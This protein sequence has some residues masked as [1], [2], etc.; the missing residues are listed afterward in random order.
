MERRSFLGGITVA[1][2]SR[3][4]GTAD[5]DVSRVYDVRQFGASG[6]G[7]TDDTIAIRRALTELNKAGGVLALPPGDYVVSA[8]LDLPNAAAWHVRGAGRTVTRIR[9]GGAAAR[10]ELFRCAHGHTRSTFGCSIEDV[11]IDAGGY[12]GTAVRLEGLTLFGMRGV[13]IVRARGTAMSLVGLFDSY[14]EDVFLEGCGTPAEPALSCT[15][16]AVGRWEAMNNCVFVNLHVEGSP[17]AVHVYIE[18]S[19]DN[20]TDTLQFYS[21]KCHGNPKTG[22]PARP[23]LVLGRY[24]IGC[25]FT[26]GLMGW[27]KGVSQIEVDGRGNKFTGID[28]GAGPPGGSPEFA[29]RFTEHAVGN[30]I[31]TPNF[32]NGVGPEFYRSG[33]VRVERGASHNKLLFPQMSTGPLPIDR[34]LSDEGRGTLFLGDD[35]GD[36]RGLYLKHGLGFNVL[37]ANGISSTATPAWNLRG[38]VSIAG[39]S[40]SA[41]VRFHTAEADANYVVTCSASDARGTPPAGARRVWISDKSEKGFRVHCEEAPGGGDNAVTVDWILVR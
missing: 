22:M 29:Y 40:D 14:F 2:L 19:Q 12:A 1:A 17:D 41:E 39:R 25:S 32:K 33:Y 11:T 9:L 20:P 36:G 4:A 35:I 5:E 27:G 26:G 10:G 38:S 31:V 16:P 15:A 28:H 23:M 30:H 34:V 18:G 21:L 3:R 37:R 13:S 8:P 6:D 24:A 7:R